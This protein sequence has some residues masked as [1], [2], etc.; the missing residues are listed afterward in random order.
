MHW[1]QKEWLTLSEVAQILGVHPS[2]VRIWANQGKIPVHRTRGGHRRFRRDEIELWVMASK[3]QKG[4]LNIP[5]DFVQA[6]LQQ[7][8]AHVDSGLI[9]QQP[10]YQKL[11]PEA[12][13]AYARGGQMMLRS[14]WNVLISDDEE[15]IRVEARALGEENALNGRR[16]GLS[17]AEALSAFFF[18]SNAL[19]EAV[20]SVIENSNAPSPAAWVSMLRK[21]KDFVIVTAKTMLE[22]YE[23]HEH[24]VPL[25]SG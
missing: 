12:R 7:V 6:T 19:L 11:S 1:Q 9:A 10:W 15:A 23:A 14:L 3:H 21:I 4:E 16:N 5:H 25:A 17:M 20:L 8:R 24:E 2:T 13:E 18:F 22:V